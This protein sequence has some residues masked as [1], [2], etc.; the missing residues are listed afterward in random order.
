MITQV[1]YSP[2][3]SSVFINNTKSMTANNTTAAVP[4][5][6]LTGAVLVIRLYGVVLTALGNHTAAAFRLNDQTLQTD[7]T[8]N[9]G[10]SLSSASAGS[11]IAK[12]ALATS[13]AQASLSSVGRFNEG[14]TA[15]TRYYG[16]FNLTKKSGATTDIEYVYTTTDTPTSGSIQF[17]VEYI[18]VSS[19]GALVSV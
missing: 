12:R 7:I 14:S 16:E 17:F 18:P 15:G 11:V 10:V 9:T 3:T 13:A 2:A 4:I 5:F 19:D 8:L 6:R 1:N